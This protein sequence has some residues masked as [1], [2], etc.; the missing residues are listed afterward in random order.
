MKEVARKTISPALT[1]SV[2]TGKEYAKRV[3]PAD[4][5]TYVNS[6]EVIPAYQI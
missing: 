2:I 1:K 5:G 4:T 6:F 3:S